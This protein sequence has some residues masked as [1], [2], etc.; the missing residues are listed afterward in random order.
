MN[1]K[2]DIG[3][4]CSGKF[5]QRKKTVFTSAQGLPSDKV[6]CLL[7]DSGTLYAGTEEGLAVLKAGAFETIFREPLSGSIGCLALVN[8]SIAVG[9]ENKLYY[10]NGGE[11][12]LMRTFK[13]KVVD[14]VDK[15]GL[16]WV[17]TEGQLLCTSYDCSCDDVCRP[18]EGGAGQ[19]LAVSDKYIYVATEDNLSVIHGKRK[20]WKNIIPRFT[21]TMPV[22]TVTALAFDETGYLWTGSEDGIFVH[23]NGN[24]WLGSDSIRTLPKNPAYRIVTDKVGG[25]Y[26]ASDVGVIYQSKGG[27][28]YFSADR[29]VPSN[30]V[31]DI[32]VAD[33]GSVFYAATDKGISMLEAYETTLE[34]KAAAF[35]EIMEKYHNRL[36]YTATRHIEN[37]D[38][39]TGGVDISDNDGLWTATYVAAESYRYAVTGSEEALSRARRGMN[40]LLLLTKISGLPGFTARAVRYPGERGYGDGDKEWALSPDGSCEWKG[41][42]SSDEMTGHFF[43]FSVYYDLCADEKEKEEIR[44][45]LCGIM[46]HIIR[47][48]YRLIDRDGLPTTWANWNPQMLNFDDKWFFERGINSLELMA[49]LKV[50]YHISGDERYNEL[51]NSFISDHHYPLNIMQHKVRDAHVCHIDDNLGFLAAFTLLRL[52]DNE[53]VRS[54]VLCGM[55]D[56]WVYERVEKQPMFC[57][58]HAIFTGRDAD[59]V[60][61]VQSLR[62]M[63]LDLVHYAMENSKRRDIIY[64]TEQEEWHEPAQPKYPLPFDERNI[65]R[66]DASVFELDAPVCGRAQEGTY[67]LL[68][69]WIGRYYGI[70]REE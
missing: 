36:G 58:F 27:L 10:L 64:D 59:L 31:N 13:D 22:H 54:Y 9:C 66:P 30:K 12:R 61:G 34:E 69:Y 5:V 3:C 33:D 46:D 23:D 70:L 26:F 20:E 35:E 11:L 49:F 39:A 7:I 19:C 8:G 17:L 52:E 37:Y 4:Y 29:W 67:F 63:P 53:A 60:E 47:N 57:F 43:G 21:P 41:E 44:A 25:R 16:L 56:H 24:L 14:A 51:Y 1:L 68:P 62:E 50:S 15:R 28:K 45:A 40:A 18:L 6:N 42:T 55:E 32:A 48:N 65:H 38:I 2:S